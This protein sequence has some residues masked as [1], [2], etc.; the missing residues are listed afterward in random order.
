MTARA[1]GGGCCGM[2]HS[3][4]YSLQNDANRIYETIRAAKA[5]RQ[6][7]RLIEVVVTNDQL[8]GQPNLG[9]ILSKEGFK[10]VNRFLNDNSGNICNVFHFIEARN[11]R[12][13]DAMSK[14]LDPAR[15][16]EYTPPPPPPPPQ[17]QT[18]TT[19]NIPFFNYRDRLRINKPGHR[20]HHLEFPAAG[21]RSWNRYCYY[22]RSRFRW[23]DV[24]ILR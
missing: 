11:Q 18:V 1:H 6:P 16:P 21:I 7:G 15:A 3:V 10:L 22:R 13:V 17:W 9:P 4:G 2:R 23:E 5:G 24:E 20:Y 19:L 8:N 14:R 12:K